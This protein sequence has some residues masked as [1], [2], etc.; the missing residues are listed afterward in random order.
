MEGHFLANMQFFLRC[1]VCKAATD[2][3]G[4]RLFVLKLQALTK[5]PFHHQLSESSWWKRFG[6]VWAVLGYSFLCESIWSQIHSRFSIFSK[7]FNAT[8]HPWSSVGGLQDLF[9]RRVAALSAEGLRE[10]PALISYD[11]TGE[12]SHRMSYQESLGTRTGSF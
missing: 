7:D 9:F 6:K 2:D 11:D 5:R 8:S 10:H 3:V 1:L 4:D 12:E